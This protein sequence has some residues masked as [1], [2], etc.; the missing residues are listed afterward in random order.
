[1]YQ[2]L[3]PWDADRIVFYVS[4]R[5]WAAQLYIYIY[6]YVFYLSGRLP[7][8]RALTALTPRVGPPKKDLT[9]VGGRGREGGELRSE[10]M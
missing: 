9:R 7:G 8:A 1:M 2:G 6:K 4:G 5:P 3:L 10:L